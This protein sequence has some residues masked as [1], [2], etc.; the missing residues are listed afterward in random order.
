MP[1]SSIR[2]CCTASS[3]SGSTRTRTSSMHS[4]I[5]ASCGCSFQST[6]PPGSPQKP[7]PGSMSR[8]TSRTRPASSISAATTTFG[9]R[10]KTRSHCG[11]T[12][13]RCFATSRVS[14]FDPQLE[15]YTIIGSGIARWPSSSDAP[16]W[17]TAWFARRNPNASDQ[18]AMVAHRA[19]GSG[20]SRD[21]LAFGGRQQREVL[22]TQWRGLQ[23]APRLC[24][25]D[26][27][28]LV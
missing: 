10:K 17:P 19:L 28:V 18:A 11:Q 23:R 21:L 15:Q 22:F 7:R 6:Y 25:R 8:R 3:S 9:L 14:V 26:D 16:A 20:A 2:M 13:R 24:R 27:F 12:L 5:S 4:R 1:S